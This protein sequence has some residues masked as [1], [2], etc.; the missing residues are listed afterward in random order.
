[1]SAEL[2]DRRLKPRIKIEGR[3]T[4]YMEDSNHTHEG[5]LEESDMGALIWI[6][7]DLP[8][9]SQLFCRVEADDEEKGSI[10]FTATLLHTHPQQRESLYGFGCTIDEVKLPD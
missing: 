6:K 10:K 9:A 2:H 1:M 8:P 5:E 3:I 7:Q 4:Y